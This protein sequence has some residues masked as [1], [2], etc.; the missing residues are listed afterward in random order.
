MHQMAGN[1][2]H[3]VQHSSALRVVNFSLIA[4]QEMLSLICHK[5]VHLIIWNQGYSSVKEN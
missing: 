5:R 1:T 2:N 3:F 4:S